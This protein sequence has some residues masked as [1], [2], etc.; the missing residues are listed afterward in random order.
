VEAG[1]EPAAIVS[2][3]IDFVIVRKEAWLH[4]N[5]RKLLIFV[6]SSGGRP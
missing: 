1:L 3:Q 4:K 5:P 6:F 2:F